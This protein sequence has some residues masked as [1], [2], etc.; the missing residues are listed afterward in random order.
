[1]ADPLLIHA[2][3]VRTM[4]E[5]VLF[6]HIGRCG[7]VGCRRRDLAQRFRIAYETVVCACERL[8]ELKLITEASRDTGR[9]CAI[10]YIVTRKGWELLTTPADFSLFPQQQAAIP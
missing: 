2:A 3:G 1:M 9:G 5:L 8:A 10:N 6:I 7:L 4:T